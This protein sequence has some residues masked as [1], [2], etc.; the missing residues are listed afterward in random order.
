MPRVLAG[1]DGFV[2]T[3]AKPV[4]KT[5]GSGQPPQYFKTIGDFGTYIA[6]QG[7]KSA[8]LELEILDRRM[9]GN[10]PNFVRGIAALGAET[11]A[12]GML[13]GEQEGLD[14]VFGELPGRVFSFAP[15]GTA[16][17]LEF[18]DGKIFLA[19]RY[20][21]SGDPWPLVEA[22]LEKAPSPGTD[23]LLEGADLVVCLNWSELAFMDELWQKLLEKCRALFSREKEKRML[24]DLCDFSRKSRGELDRVMALLECFSALRTVTL[25]LNRNEALLL[26]PGAEDPREIARNIARRYAIDE[27]LI[28]SHDGALLQRGDETFT[29]ETAL[30]PEP[31]ISTGAGDHFNAAYAFAALE[32]RAPAERLN[33][34]GRCAGAYISTGKSPCREE[35]LR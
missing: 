8:S 27:I 18:D 5:G 34:A 2:D 26:E 20:A 3:I 11:W 35:G 9:G 19:P 31:K 4:M 14:P 30:V 33:F 28:H 22:A 23:A 6:G 24:F 25:S 12:I 16:T 17:A 13:G 7:G 21:L 15:A 10:M 1:F 29:A 32:G